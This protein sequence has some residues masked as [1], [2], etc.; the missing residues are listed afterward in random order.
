L[1]TPGG[2]DV[3]FRQVALEASAPDR[4]AEA[5]HCQAIWPAAGEQDERVATAEELPDPFRQRI[6]WCGGLVGFPVKG[7][8]QL[9]DGGSGLPVRWANLGC[10]ESS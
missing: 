6:G 2:S 1:P 10:H 3:Q 7:L 9:H 5:E 4:R 8:E